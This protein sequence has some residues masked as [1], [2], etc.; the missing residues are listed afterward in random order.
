MNPMRLNVM[1][2]I[3][4]INPLTLNVLDYV[5]PNK[6]LS[7]NITNTDLLPP[8]IMNQEISKM[9]HVGRYKLDIFIKK[10]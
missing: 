8:P 1:N 4:P 2:P 7:L 5:V 10:G 3:I 9:P 6:P